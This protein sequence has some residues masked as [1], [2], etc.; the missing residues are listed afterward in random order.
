[1]AR[2]DSLHCLRC[3]SLRQA[4]NACPA[5]HPHPHPYCARV[6]VVPKRGSRLAA[7][8]R[9]AH[10][11]LQGLPAKPVQD[12]WLAQKSNGMA[13]ISGKIHLYPGKN[14]KNLYWKRVI[15]IFILVFI[16]FFDVY[17]PIDSCTDDRLMTETTQ[18]KRGQGFLPKLRAG[19]HLTCERVARCW[20][21]F[22]AS[23]GLRCR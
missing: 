17:K 22:Y 5:A 23:N 16:Q 4:G 15:G 9:S 11:P 10:R 20:R 6:R 21:R 13:V 19:R 18:P 14:T 3:A 2:D 1:M 7:S 8:P 12:C